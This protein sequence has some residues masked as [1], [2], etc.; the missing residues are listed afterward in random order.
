[1]DIR[2]TDRHIER[3]RQ[4]TGMAWWNRTYACAYP[5][6]I[7]HIDLPIKGRSR[8][9]LKE[10]VAAAAECLVRGPFQEEQEQEQ[11]QWA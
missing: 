5:C 2:D 10:P 11:E 7:P 3:K 6:Q 4:K 1:M 8:H 9:A